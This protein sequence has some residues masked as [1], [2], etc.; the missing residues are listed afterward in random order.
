MTEES[1]GV[2]ATAERSA[3]SSQSESTTT[4]VRATTT[5]RLVAGVDGKYP[6]G[7]RQLALWAALP[8]FLLAS[9]LTV[10]FAV[11]HIENQLAEEAAEQLGAAGIDTDG[12]AI[13][14]DYRD[15]EATGALPAGV[16]AAAADAA[17]AEEGLLRN[18]DIAATATD[19][20]AGTAPEPDADPAAPVAGAIGPVAVQA[21]FDGDR[22]VVTGTVLDEDQRSQVLAAVAAAVAPAEVVDQLEV[23]GG[24]A[25]VPGAAG[26]LTGL[27]TALATLGGVPG[28][29]ADLTD[30]SLAITVDEAGDGVDLDA[31]T[32]LPDSITEVATT[33]DVPADTK[34]DDPAAGEAVVEA[35]ITALQDE[36]D[37]LRAEIRETVVFATSSSVLTAP[38]QATLDKVVAAMNRYPLPVVE[39][40]GHTDSLGP[41]G[42]NQE[43]SQAR[44]SAV[45]DYLVASGV[46]ADRLQFRG[47][48]E[49]EPI[50]T[51]DTAEGQANNRRVEL[52]AL[53][54]FAVE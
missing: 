30:E 51:N 38:A 23:T 6:W 54:D 49:D 10:P 3:S 17:V 15:G 42:P 37:G 11:A 43:L 5:K 16:T 12:L 14:F 22:A 13:D 40:A 26:R 34:A 44:A 35:E 47:A 7:W 25:E 45:V 27:T 39:V 33:V 48:G 53:A 50:D 4:T 28:W 46:D 29:R 9:I 18:F 31:I 36:L 41:A 52:T 20:A 24:E 21:V 19:T 8:L 2:T 1:T 32:A